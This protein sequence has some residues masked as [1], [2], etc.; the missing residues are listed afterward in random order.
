MILQND[1]VR[2]RAV[3]PADLCL[4][5][6]LESDPA[7]AE[8]NF[9]TAPASRHMVQQYIDNYSADIHKQGQLRLIIESV[10]DNFTPVGTIDISDFNPHDG[11]GFVGIAILEQWRDRSLGHNSLSLLCDYAA[12]TLGMHQLAAQV[13]VDNTASRALFAGAGFKSAGR[14]RSWLRRGKQYADVL[15]FQRL[16]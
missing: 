13:A 2:L 1:L 3:E 16:F 7:M 14:L 15:I 12:N 10:A 6:T 8:I 11:R 9:A 5:L 4:L